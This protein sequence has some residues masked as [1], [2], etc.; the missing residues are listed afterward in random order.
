[1]NSGISGQM[2]LQQ[3]HNRVSVIKYDKQSPSHRQGVKR[4]VLTLEGLCSAASA[5]WQRQESRCPG[6]H[7]ERPEERTRRTGSGT[8]LRGGGESGKSSHRRCAFSLIKQ[9]RLC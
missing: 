1:M 7:L 3:L 9:G 8:K 4:I 2:D 5:P 6:E